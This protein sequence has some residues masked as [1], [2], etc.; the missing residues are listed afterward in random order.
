MK[1]IKAYQDCPASIDRLIKFYDKQMLAAASSGAQEI[2]GEESLEAHFTR[3]S[4]YDN[5]FVMANFILF[6]LDQMA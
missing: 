1:Q 4:E 3:S 6:I 5:F 2:Y